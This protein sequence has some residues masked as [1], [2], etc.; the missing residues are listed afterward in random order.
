MPDG[1]CAG[2]R[3]TIKVSFKVILRRDQASGGYFVRCPVLQGCVSRG[4]TVEEALA[5]IEQAIRA[6]LTVFYESTN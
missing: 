6:Y 2:R 5:N 1:D 4:T 3:E